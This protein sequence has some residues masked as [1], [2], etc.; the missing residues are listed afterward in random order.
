VRHA[1]VA[2]FLGKQVRVH[3]RSGEVYTGYLQL[4]DARLLL[5]LQQQGYIEGNRVYEVRSS[6]SHPEIDVTRYMIPDPSTI[7]RIE[8]VGS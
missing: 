3:Q 7:A 1:E 8:V 2:K 5:R 4:A 6:V